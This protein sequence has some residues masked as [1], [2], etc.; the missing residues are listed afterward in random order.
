MR[1]YF[2][3]VLT[4]IN[5]KLFKFNYFQAGNERNKEILH[6]ETTSSYS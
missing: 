4:F 5:K 1:I 2:V 3:Y 6:L